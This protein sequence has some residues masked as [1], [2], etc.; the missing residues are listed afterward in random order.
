[1]TEVIVDVA[2][3]DGET[4]TQKIGQ[5]IGLVDVRKMVEP[6]MARVLRQMRTERDHS[7]VGHYTVRFMYE[8]EEVA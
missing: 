1:M 3:R 8:L 4:L 2:L 7:Q 5:V 6:G